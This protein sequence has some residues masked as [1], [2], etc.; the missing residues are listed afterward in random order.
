MVV[1]GQHVPVQVHGGIVWRMHRALRGPR[2]KPRA[3]HEALD[4]PRARDLQREVPVPRLGRERPEDVLLELEELRVRE[5]EFAVRHAHVRHDPLEV[6]GHV[7]QPRVD[8]VDDPVDVGVRGR[9]HAIDIAL[10]L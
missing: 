1:A 9:E 6:D 4:H 5:H 7:S 10:E 3:V 8:V 2:V